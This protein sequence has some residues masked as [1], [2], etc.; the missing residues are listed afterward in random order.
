MGDIKK[1]FV[2]AVYS[3]R[4]IEKY[5]KEQV[6]KRGGMCMKWSGQLGVPDRIVITVQH[7]VIFVE[8]KRPD[9]NLRKSQELMHKQMRNAGARIAVIYNHDEVDK[10]IS[11][12]LP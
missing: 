12:Y 10:F 2:R 11:T 4:T 5:L 8:M 3:E 6:E 7:G 1:R 9:G